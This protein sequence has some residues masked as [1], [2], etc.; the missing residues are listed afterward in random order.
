MPFDSFMTSAI[1]SEINEQICGRKVDKVCQP[2]RDEIDLIFHALVRNRLVINCSA[3]TPFVA[4]SEQ[5]KENPATPPMMCMLL[6]KHLSRARV[7]SVEQIGFD[8]IIRIAFESG[9]DL[10]FVKNKYLYCEMMGRGSNLIFVDENNRILASF[11]QNDLTTKFERVIMVGMEYQPMPVGERVNPI[12][13]TKEQFAEIFSSMAGSRCD[14]IF[15]KQ[16][17]GF[18]KL[19]AREIVFLASGDPDATTETINL[20]KLWLA[21]SNVVERVI[22]KK[23]EPCLIYSSKESFD[24]GEAPIDFSFMPIKSLG[25]DAFCFSCES[26]SETIEKFYLKRNLEERRRQHYNDIFQILKTCKN[27]LEKK[28]SVLLQQKEDSSDAEQDKLFGDLIMQELYRI[29]RGDKTLAA[30]DYSVD[31]PV[32]RNILL[33]PIRSPSQ[34]A[35]RYYK[36]Y[37]KKK[38]A[39]LKAEEQIEIAKREL[40]YA[41]SI[42]STLDNAMTSTDL[43]QIRQELSFW[44]YGRRLLASLKKPS[45]K[46]EKIK[47][48]SVTLPSGF[49]L[50]LGLNNLQNDEIST[51]LAEKEDLWFHVKNYHGSHVL[52]KA[53]K[54]QEFLDS[55]I[56]YAAALAAYYS[57]VRESKRV[58]VD[59]TRARYIKKPGGSNPGFITYRNHYS[60]VVD[61]KPLN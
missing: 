37:N 16:F 15:Q 49:V 43:A 56:E 29:K 6:R 21:F 55:D 4:L 18:G 14:Q 60:M 31:P 57:E 17:L 22:S 58:E 44:N 36:E 13:C 25:K 47:P 52:L 59:Y 41:E 27:R 38:T 12:V 46:K 10:G 53:K 19:T 30:L 42:L 35:Q 54:D 32:L 1:T 23:F 51:S 7:S 39:L 3:A 26:V 34:N 48:K 11:Y 61:P 2:E 8:R 40:M 9:D 45:K 28:I 24:Q 50:F 20:E 5:S 33:D